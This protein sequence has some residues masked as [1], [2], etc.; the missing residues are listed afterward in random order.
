MPST[1]QPRLAL[2]L[3]MDALVAKRT[4]WETLLHH[5]VTFNKMAQAR[6]ETTVRASERMYKQ[7]RCLFLFE[8]T[9][10]EPEVYDVPLNSQD[11]HFYSVCGCVTYVCVV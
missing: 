2:Q 8:M 6:M 5:T 11:K 3:H 4:F 10:M 9:P 1:L 7:V